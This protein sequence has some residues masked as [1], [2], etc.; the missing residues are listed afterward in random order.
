MRSGGD[1]LVASIHN[2]YSIDIDQTARD[3]GEQFGRIEPAEGFLRDQQ[4][5]PDHG[6][7]VLHLLE[8]L[9]RGRPEPHRG[10]RRL[11][12]VRRPQVLPVLA[13]E[14]VERHHALP[15][16]VER[17]TRPPRG[18]ASYTTPGTPASAAP[19]PP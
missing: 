6:R 19:P 16:P 4:R 7:R 12:W 10:E 18:R 9:D 11:D 3:V 2:T 8:P 14:R 5:L 13:R 1:L 15:V 17:A